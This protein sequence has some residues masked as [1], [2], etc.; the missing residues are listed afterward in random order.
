M[1]RDYSIDILKFLA[2]IIITWSHFEK[3]L[4]E[5][6]M[7]ATGGA[8]GDTLFFFASGYTLLISKKGGNFAN[9][10]K[11]RINRI[12]PTVF[13]WA[14][15]TSIIFGLTWNMPYILL[16]GGGFFVTCIMVFYLFF[17]PIKKYLSAYMGGG[18]FVVLCNSGNSL[19]LRRS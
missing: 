13:A 11:R 14:L 16:Y 8:F 6:E 10:Y 2:A 3:P 4:G 12:Y 19:F 1:Q 5:F 9:W 17:Y 7:L 18:N 15:L